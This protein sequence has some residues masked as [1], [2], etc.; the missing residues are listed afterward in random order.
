M[1]AS[2]IAMMN[3]EN[4][5][6]TAEEHFDGDGHDHTAEPIAEEHFEGDGHDHTGETAAEEHFEGDGHD[7]SEEP[8]AEEHFEGDGHDHSEEPTA[9]EHF[10]GDGH[11]HSELPSDY[12]TP[13]A[14]MMHMAVDYYDGK[15]WAAFNDHTVEAEVTHLDGVPISGHE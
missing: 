14:G 12:G 6:P 10:E 13:P 8:T 15:I 11:D 1:V 3:G 7:H 4:G 9:E 2:G 5:E